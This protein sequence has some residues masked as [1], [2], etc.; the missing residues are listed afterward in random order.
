LAIK[1][2]QLTKSAKIISKQNSVLANKIQ[3]KI[4]AAFGLIK[5]LKD[6]SSIDFA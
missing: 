4:N 6:S 1:Q 2:K 5:K 3:N